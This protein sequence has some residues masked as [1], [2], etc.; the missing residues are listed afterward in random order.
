METNRDGANAESPFPLF[1][2]FFASFKNSSPREKVGP[3]GRVSVCIHYCP[4]I[5]Y[6]SPR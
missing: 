1:F 2:S 3:V 6:F 4:E 5:K